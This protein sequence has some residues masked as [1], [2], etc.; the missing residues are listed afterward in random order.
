MIRSRVRTLIRT[1][2]SVL[3]ALGTLCTAAHSLEVS[4][5]KVLQAYGN[6]CWNESRS[7]AKSDEQLIKLIRSCVDKKINRDWSPPERLN[8]VEFPSW[9]VRNT[10]AATA[11]GVILFIKG[12]NTTSSRDDFALIPY[13]LKTLNERGWDVVSVKFPESLKYLRTPNIRKFSDSAV[14]YVKEKAE[15]LRTQGYRKVV[16]AGHSWGGWVALSSAPS[17][18]VDSLIIDSPSRYPFGKT[19]PNGKPNP[20]IGKNQSEV[21]DLLSRNNKP[22][23]LAVFDG[24]E[25]SRDLGGLAEGQLKRSKA[26][27]VLLDRPAGFSG[28]FSSWLPIF[29]FAYG[30]CIQS[31]IEVTRKP[32]EPP[33][34][35]LTDFRSA[36][37]LKPDSEKLVF[38]KDAGSRDFVTYRLNDFG[39]ERITF[40]DATTLRSHAS[41]HM[42]THRFS[43]RGSVFCRQGKCSTL[44]PFAPG[45]L[46]EFTQDGRFH[47]WWIERK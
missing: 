39:N 7:I 15:A 38:Q 33:A 34:L 30:E 46:L 10:G 24:D 28:H 29:D 14:P 6:Q 11:K 41:R 42:L 16:L 31:F 18:A 21:V 27:Y 37:I 1:Q 9:L 43:V 47:A 32:C 12:W 4:K 35:S 26:R 45:K 22:T 20:F 3:L 40:L 44:V 25:S 23:W 36:M 2:L 8:L 17:T 5:T 13:F 19:L